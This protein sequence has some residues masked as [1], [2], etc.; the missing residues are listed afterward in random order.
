MN[1]ERG[2][3]TGRLATDPIFKQIITSFFQ[4]WEVDI[5]TE[6]EVAR[7]P[8]KIDAVVRV[9]I[10]AL[11]A[12]RYLT[13]F[14]YFLVYNVV[15]FKGPADALTIHGYQRIL[16]RSYQYLAE[17]KLDNPE[18]TLTL[19]SARTPR[20]VLSKSYLGFKQ[21][22]EGYYLSNN[23]GL[24]VYLIA[25]NELPIKPENYSLLLFASSKEKNQKIIEEIVKSE[26]GELIQYAF[27]L[28]P[29]ITEEIAMANRFRLPRRNM[30]LIAQY[31]G[32]DL[33]TFINPEDRVQDLTPAQR[34]EGLS[35][36]DR[37]ALLQL[38]ANQ[39]DLTPAQ[40]LQGLSLEDIRDGLSDEE[41]QALRQL[42]DGQESDT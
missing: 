16:S 18:L 7:L 23:G 40:R 31:L 36:E 5:Q 30:E 19:V 2:S 26:R 27:L 1:S 35:D 20:T 17:H 6:V 28:H 4:G 33:V 8:R 39:E 12:I 42:L 3:E 13:P 10:R 37:Q 9:P 11:H 22:A 29:D 34:L 25:T 14:W 24:P 38:W 32:R 21:I 15:E 41:R